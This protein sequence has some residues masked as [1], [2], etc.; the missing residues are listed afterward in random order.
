MKISYKILLS[1]TNR[2]LSQNEK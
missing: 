1:Q 2:L